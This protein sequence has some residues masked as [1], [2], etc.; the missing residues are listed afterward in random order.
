M[1]IN[2]S[3]FSGIIVP[4]ITPFYKNDVDFDSLEKLGDYYLKNK[5]DAFVICGTTGEPATLS[6][7]E[8]KLILDFM[9]KKYGA[10]LPILAGIAS[11]CTE[12]AMNEARALQDAGA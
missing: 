6:K 5:A 12:T 4:L 7:E 1:Y 8:K 9:I 2:P 10:Q 3:T 11:S